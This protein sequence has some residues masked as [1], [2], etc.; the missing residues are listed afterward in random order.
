MID[1]FVRVKT[2]KDY[3]KHLSDSEYCKKT[4]LNRLLALERFCGFVE[5]KIDDLATKG[6]TSRKRTKPFEKAV[7]ETFEWINAQSKIYRPIA[8]K[9]TM[10]RNTRESLE[11]ENR[12]I[13]P[14]KLFEKERECRAHVDTLMEQLI[15]NPN[16]R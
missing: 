2:I 9:E 4:I 11:Q 12:W 13:S 1:C 10:T 15:E 14:Q 16:Q 7:A 6:L 3:I 5:E 8:T